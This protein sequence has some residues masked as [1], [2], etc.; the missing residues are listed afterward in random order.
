MSIQFGVSEVIRASPERILDAMLDLERAHLW[1]PGLV[2][3]EPLSPGPLAVGSEWSETRKFMGKEATEQFEITGLDRPHRLDLRVDGSKGTTGKGEYL[4]AYRLEPEGKATTVHLS[5]E[6]R[7]MTGIMGWLGKLLV[8]PYKK[9]CSK[10]MAAL[11]SYLEEGSS[12]PGAAE[13]ERISEIP[14]GPTQ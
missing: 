1:M 7:G 6:I 10:D 5:G 2:R 3:M 14:E 4:F 13:R 12:A 9:A 8:G 11:K